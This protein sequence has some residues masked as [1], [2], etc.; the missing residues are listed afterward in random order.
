MVQRM[1]NGCGGLGRGA[2]WI[3]SAMYC[4]RCARLELAGGSL[5]GLL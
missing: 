2:Q 3:V 4:V 5:G 1:A